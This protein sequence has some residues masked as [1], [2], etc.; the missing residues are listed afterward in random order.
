[1]LEGYDRP[2]IGKLISTG[3]A[4]GKYV[5]SFFCRKLIALKILKVS[6]GHSGKVLIAAVG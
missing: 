5:T 2:Q 3:W 6:G 4:K 1:M